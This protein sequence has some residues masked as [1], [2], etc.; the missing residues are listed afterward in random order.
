MMPRS[1]P[2]LIPSAG[3]HERADR[4]SRAKPAGAV[5]QRLEA[6]CSKL[7]NGPLN[8]TQESGIASPATTDSCEI[9]VTGMAVPFRLDRV[10]R[11]SATMHHIDFVREEVDVAVRHGDGNWSGLDAVRFC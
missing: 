1:V 7:R 11:V 8:Q 5:A 9:P 2:N 3:R 10:L 6:L 4:R